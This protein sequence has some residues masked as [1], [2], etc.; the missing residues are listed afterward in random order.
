MT[1]GVAWAVHAV[2]Y[3]VTRAPLAALPTV[4]WLALVPDEVISH[5]HLWRVVTYA[6][7]DLPNGFDGLWS[8]LA[9]WFFGT[10]IEQREGAR[11]I[12]WPWAVGAIGGAV[13]LL[14][15]RFAS[16]EYGAAPAM[17]LSSILTSALIVRWG[18]VHARERVS[19]FGLAEMDGRV[20]A[21][22]LSGIGVV[23]ALVARS[24]I[25][26]ASVGATI[27]V[28][29]V[30][31]ILARRRGSGGGGGGGRGRRASGPF[32]VIDGGRRDKPRWV[33]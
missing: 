8:A 14:G 26:L 30:S 17:G 12:V 5:G 16:A 9:L 19:F 3:W 23:N 7:L 2:L 15:V 1:V 28:A 6:A 25:G 21:A 13:T 11:G 4:R 31:L 29:L 20:L 24:P 18:F 22:I 33:N 10:P 32:T 27:S